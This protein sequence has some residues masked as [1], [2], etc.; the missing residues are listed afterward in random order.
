MRSRLC[1]AG[2]GRRILGVS[3]GGSIHQSSGS[4]GVSGSRS[5]RS[6]SGVGAENECRPWTLMCLSARGEKPTDI[7]V[8]D[9]VTFSA[10]FD[11]CG[12]DVSGV[13]QHDGIDDEAENAELVFLSL[14][15]FLAEFTALAVEHVAGNTMAGFLGAEAGVDEAP[16]SFV[17]GVDH[18]KQVEGFCGSAVLG[19]RCAEHAWHRPRTARPRSADHLL[20][21]VRCS[22]RAVDGIESRSSCR[23]TSGLRCPRTT[24]LCERWPIRE[25]RTE[26]GL[27]NPVDDDQPAP[28]CGPSAVLDNRNAETTVRPSMIR[29]YAQQQVLHIDHAQLDCRP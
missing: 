11:E 20:Q 18:R 7:G 17:V 15:I 12:V 14:P 23:I 3:S 22:G 29:H 2:R 28:Q 24:S 27:C 26:R 5:G 13:P 19:D 25:S 21:I 10:E 16:I 4:S 8:V 9:G 1:G 6:P